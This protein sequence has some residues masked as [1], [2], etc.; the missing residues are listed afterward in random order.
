ML[1]TT[2]NADQPEKIAKR[3]G[4]GKRRVLL[5][6]ET[7]SGKSTLAIGLARWLDQAGKRH[8]LIGTDPGSPA[9]GIPG[10]NL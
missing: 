4:R 3:L 6:G 9:F 7:G 8:R 2:F 10:A 5:F 1:P